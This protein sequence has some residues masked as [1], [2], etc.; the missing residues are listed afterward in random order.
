MLQW[1]FF[2]SFRQVVIVLNALKYSNSDIGG[3][4]V[5]DEGAGTMVAVF[6]GSLFSL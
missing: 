1:T 5:G 3:P 6:S 2:T 4:G